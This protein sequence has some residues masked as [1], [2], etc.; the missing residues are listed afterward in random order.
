VERKDRAA[1]IEALAKEAQ[2]DLAKPT[3][4][5]TQLFV[6]RAQEIDPSMDFLDINKKIALQKFY[7]KDPVVMP[8]KEI[9]P[10]KFNKTVN[11][12]PN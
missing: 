7:A 5:Y 1:K 2:N 9:K 6:E 8:N 3:K 12:Q 4:S 10:L 11:L